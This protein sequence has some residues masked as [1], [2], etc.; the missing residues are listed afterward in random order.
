MLSIL[1]GGRAQAD[2]RKRAAADRDRSVIG[3]FVRFLTIRAGGETFEI[4]TGN[5]EGKVMDTAI[6]SPKG[7]MSIMDFS[8]HQRLQ[9]DVGNP[10]QIAHARAAFERL[11]AH[12][13]AAFG[14]R[15]G[16]AA[17]HPIKTFDPTMNEVVMV[18][19]I[20]GG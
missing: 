20:V 15:N 10:D 19:R 8:G 12:G 6:G 11:M 18:P 2:A 13:Y 17:K 16:T 4:F 5:R 1:H 9:W 14:S 3:T 7:E